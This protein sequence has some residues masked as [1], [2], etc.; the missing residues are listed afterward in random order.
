MLRIKNLSVSYRSGEP[1]IKNINLEFKEK[2]LLLGPNGAGKST[3]FRTLCGLTP[4]VSGEII[5]DGRDFDSI[6]GEP[7]ILIANIP[8][9]FQLLYDSVY[10]IIDLYAD[11]LEGDIDKILHIIENFGLS[12]EFL[13]KRKLGEL[14]SGQQKIV[15]NSIVLGTK[16]KIKLFDE[17]FEQLDPAKKND[18]LEHLAKDNSLIILST[19]ETWVLEKLSNWD[20]VF[21][22]DGQI[23]G[24]LK[25]DEL[26][27]SYLIYKIVPSS[28]LTVK[29]EKITF[30]LVKEPIQGARKLEDFMS[31][32][33][34][35]RYA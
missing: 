24:T 25:A 2:T 10:N 27:G 31:L 16:A 13:K 28:L 8:E 35:Y 18:L 15:L 5:I 6:Y 33:Y 19:H 32:D 26:I 9:I 34:I 21:M 12:R 20:V 3:F 4:K 11:L 14:S 17:P 1:I 7:G 22:F 23:F 29:T 30:S